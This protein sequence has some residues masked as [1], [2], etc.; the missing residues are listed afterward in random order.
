MMQIFQSK[1]GCGEMRD[2][3]R[4]HSRRAQPWEGAR[5]LE[6]RRRSSL[7]AAYAVS[8]PQEWKELFVVGVR[9]TAQPQPHFYNSPEPQHWTGRQR[10]WQ[11]GVGQGTP[12]EGVNGARSTAF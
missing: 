4:G 5:H 3:G 11:A 6:T 10:G 7:A 1:A 9:Q 12:I 2:I 8:W